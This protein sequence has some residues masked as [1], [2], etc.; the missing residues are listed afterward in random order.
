MTSALKKSYEFAAPLVDK[1]IEFV[2]TQSSQM[3]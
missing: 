2:Q 3:Q 1:A